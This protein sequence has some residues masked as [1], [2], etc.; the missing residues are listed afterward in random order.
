[1]RMFV[2]YSGWLI[3]FASSDETEFI[4]KY[5]VAPARARKDFVN[6]MITKYPWLTYCGFLS[7]DVGGIDDVHQYGAVEF[8][9]ELMGQGRSMWD[10]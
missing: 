2:R 3:L 10:G 9:D 7:D 1:M 5:S 4:K 8:S 6:S